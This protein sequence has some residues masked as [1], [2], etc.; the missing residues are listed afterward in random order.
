MTKK[1]ICCGIQT[2]C[3]G[4][5]DGDAEQPPHLHDDPL[6]STQIKEHGHAEGEKVDDGQCLEHEN[7]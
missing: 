4:C 1:D 7:A 6:K 3:S 5:A 2:F